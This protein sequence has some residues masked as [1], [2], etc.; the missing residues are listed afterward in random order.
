MGRYRRKPYK[1]KQ[2]DSRHKW[3]LTEEIEEEVDI[4]AIDDDF[5][6]LYAEEET[7]SENLDEPDIVKQLR[8]EERLG[9]LPIIT[10]DDSYLEKEEFYFDPHLPEF[11]EYIP[12][13]T[14]S[15]ETPST[16]KI[17]SYDEAYKLAKKAFENL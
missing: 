9:K 6:E 17:T 3:D 5:P 11:K 13:P 7:L 16:T 8:E 1:K 14:T 4:Y 10:P 12:S 15:D 2:I